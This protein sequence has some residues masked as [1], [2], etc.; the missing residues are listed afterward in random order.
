MQREHFEEFCKQLRNATNAS[1]KAKNEAR[2][3]REER[4]IK[5]KLRMEQ[6]LCLKCSFIPKLQSSFLC[7]RPRLKTLHKSLFI[8]PKQR[9]WRNP[10][11]SFT[12]QQCHKFIPSH[13]LL[14][15]KTQFTRRKG[16]KGIVPRQRKQ[17]GATKSSRIAAKQQRR[18]FSYLLPAAAT[19]GLR[20]ASNLIPGP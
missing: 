20:C 9:T 16:T 15:D 17:G 8:I 12:R 11:N 3:R 10:W 7:Y 2:H 6:K 4:G 1:S 5:Y 13:N 19:L 18:E 14:R